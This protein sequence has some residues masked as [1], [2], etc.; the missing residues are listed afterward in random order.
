MKRLIILLVPLFIFS[1]CGSRKDARVKF[2]QAISTGDLNGGVVVFA[3]DG[4][5]HRTYVFNNGIEFES[6]GIELPGNTTWN[7]RIVSWDGSTGLGF[8][9]G[10]IRCET[11]ESLSISEGVQNITANLRNSN[12]FENTNSIAGLS[13]SIPV[14]P[15]SE[16]KPIK[17]YG[18]ADFDDG[19]GGGAEVVD[20]STAM[21]LCPSNG[22]MRGITDYYQVKI[23]SDH[24]GNQYGVQEI[25]SGCITATQTNGTD[26]GLNLPI[27]YNDNASIRY[28]I[29]AYSEDDNESCSGEKRSIVM[30]KGIADTSEYLINGLYIVDVAGDIEADAANILMAYADNIGSRGLS[31]LRDLAPKLFFNSTNQILANA[32]PLNS[33]SFILNAFSGTRRVYFN[34]SGN[35]TISQNMALSINALTGISNDVYTDTDCSLSFDSPSNTLSSFSIAGTAYLGFD[36]DVDSVQKVGSIWIATDDGEELNVREKLYETIGDENIEKLTRFF[37]GSNPDD[38]LEKKVDSTMIDVRKDYGAKGLGSVI[39][40]IHPT[41][42]NCTDLVGDGTLREISYDFGESSLVP[43]GLMIEDLPSRLIPDFIS[44]DTDANGGGDTQFDKK[45]SLYLNGSLSTVFYIECNRKV[46]MIF[47][48]NFGGGADEEFIMWNTESTTLQRFELYEESIDGLARSGEYS[49]FVKD[50]ATNYDFWSYGYYKDSTGTLNHAYEMIVTGEYED[51]LNRPIKHTLRD[52]NSGNIGTY[53]WGADTSANNFFTYA[54]GSNQ[55]V[56]LS[57]MKLSSHASC[58]NSYLNLRGVAS[59][60]HSNTAPLYAAPYSG[61][62]ASIRLDTIVNGLMNNSIFDINNF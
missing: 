29:E 50:S 62:E 4:T 41:A 54:S 26:L 15:F 8:M 10:I 1:T 55:C 7:M 28:T 40:A 61:L 38:Q 32:D 12:C 20:L 6:T 25:S 57:D 44:N 52:Y 46:G 47:E 51:I 37:D 16:F 39:A 30:K 18:C 21:G 35:C 34:N 33:M 23:F 31:P 14:G 58:S 11:F 59:D 2:T 36:V 9:T 24:P 5:E 27:G 56:N 3:S 49:R 17:L 45:I 19:T 60:D 42:N 43:V 48:S 53:T 13:I 22:L